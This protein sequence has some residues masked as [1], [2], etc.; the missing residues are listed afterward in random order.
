MIISSHQ[1]NSKEVY[2]D[3]SNRRCPT[4][5]SL[6]VDWLHVDQPAN[7]QIFRY[8]IWRELGLHLQWYLRTSHSNSKLETHSQAPSQSHHILDRCRYYPPPPPKQTIQQ[9]WDSA[10]PSSNVFILFLT[11]S[12]VQMWT[13]LSISTRTRSAEKS[14]CRKFIQ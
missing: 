11:L 8:W 13:Q 2:C 14:L 7:N 10:A 12:W 5:C 3:P 4:K 9:I 1:N 6:H